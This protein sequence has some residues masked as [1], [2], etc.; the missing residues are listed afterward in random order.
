M[1]ETEVHELMALERQGWAA[2]SRGEGRDFYGE[3]LADDAIVVVP[4]AVLDKEQTLASW[5]DVAPWQWYDL[6]GR[7]VLDF[8]CAAVVIYDVTARRRLESPYRAT[9]SSTY[10][11]RPQGWRLVVHQQT[12]WA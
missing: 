6:V 12:P 3:I 2:L 11:L 4:G 5:D 8:R 7:E 10:A 9:V 1:G